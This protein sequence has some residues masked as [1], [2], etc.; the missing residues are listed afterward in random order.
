MDFIFFG[1]LQRTVKTGIK[2]TRRKVRVVYMEPDRV[3]DN[4]VFNIV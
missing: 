1:A 2:K 3:R 4:V